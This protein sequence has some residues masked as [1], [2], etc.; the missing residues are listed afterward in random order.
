MSFAAFARRHTTRLRSIACA[1]TCAVLSIAVLAGESRAQSNMSTQGF[2]FPTGQFSSRANGSGG[3]TAEMD[4]LS[5]V[6]PASI[7]L[8]GSRLVFFQI[9]PEFRSVRV[10][11]STDHTTTARYPV[12]FGAIPIG[13]S[14][15]LAVGSSTLLDRT[16]TSVFH[17]TEQIN[18]T[19]SVDMTTNYR[20]DG[21]MNDVRVA[22]AWTP[23]KWLHLGVGAHAITGHNLI[24]ITQSFA[25]TTQFSAF[26]QQRVL[27]FSGAAASAGVQLVAKSWTLAGSVRAGGKLDLSATDTVLRSAH[28]PAHL[29]ASLSFTGIPNSALSV[30]TSHDNWSSLGSLGQ[31]D[32]TAVNAWD[33][34]V[35][36]DIAGPSVSKHPVFLRAGFRDRTLP[37]QTSNQSV[38]ERSFS[39]GLGSAFANNRVLADLAIIHASRSA[40][41]AASE[42][43]WTISIGLSVLP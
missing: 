30:R 19:E 23:E 33:T 21:A 17:T 42:S 41:I 10:G 43:A 1:I 26:T 34:S 12:V 24:S 7:G 4:P 20:V 35:G 14:W 29:G 40:N 8:L 22:T 39:G 5:P 11:D 13:S 9:E 38:T 36:A 6:N 18:A 28:V 31:G 25:D 37:F 15:V 27:S 3:A 16:A 2:G 32:I